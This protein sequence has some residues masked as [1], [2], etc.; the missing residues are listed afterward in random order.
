MTDRSDDV[1][2]VQVP[3][4]GGDVAEQRH[5]VLLAEE[6]MVFVFEGSGALPDHAG[7]VDERGSTRAEVVRHALE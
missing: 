1:E 2:G 5:S 6:A 4:R 3:P 7:S